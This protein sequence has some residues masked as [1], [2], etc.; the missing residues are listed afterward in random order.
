MLVFEFIS[1]RVCQCLA[2][3]LWWV[4]FRKFEW[5]GLVSMQ[6][7]MRGELRRDS[8]PEREREERRGETPEKWKRRRILGKYP[9]E[10]TIRRIFPMRRS[11]SNSAQS[12][13][14]P[15]HPPQEVLIDPEEAPRGA[16]TP[17]NELVWWSSN[18]AGCCGAKY[19]RS[20]YGCHDANGLSCTDWC[21]EK[22]S[23]TWAALPFS[24]VVISTPYCPTR[25]SAA[26]LKSS[27]YA[28]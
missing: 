17:D 28:Q 6:G 3:S 4:E 2:M 13:P 25:P 20:T 23:C 10:E 1:R 21:S 16:S 8:R 5:E 11:K 27:F 7:E 18:E 14:T 9:W 15:E 24:L 12:K 26:Q 22:S 19:H